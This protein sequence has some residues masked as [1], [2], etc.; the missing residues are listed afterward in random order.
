MGF[1]FISALISFIAGFYYLLIKLS[2]GAPL[3]YTSTIVS[4]LFGTSVILFSI[5]V[6][7][8]FINR[9]YDTRI[10]KPAYSVKQKL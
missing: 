2:K 1:S 9:I 10:K 8:A 5:G 7:A 4:V 6:L 3:G